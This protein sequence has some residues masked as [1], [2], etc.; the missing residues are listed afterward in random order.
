MNCFNRAYD[1]RRMVA[2]GMGVGVLWATPPVRAETVTGP[3][4]ALTD[5][6][7]A[8]STDPR[9]DHLTVDGTPVNVLVPP[10]Y[11]RG[12]R[13]YPVVYLFH[14][15]FSDEDSFSTQTDLLAYTAA[16]E[17]AQQALVVMPAGG[18]LPIGLDY[19]DG[20]QRQ[21]TFVFGTLIPFVDANYRTR[22]ERVHRAIAG[23]SAGG[24]N[25]MLYAARH[26]DMFVA[27]GS[28]SGF[29]DPFTSV[30]M[31][32]AQLFAA[33]DVQLCG[34]SVDWTSFWGDP[35][36][37]PFGWE[38]GDPTYFAGNLRG[39]A[40]YVG[41]DNGVPCPENPN[42]DPF[43]VF[44][45]QTVY[46]M[47]QALDQALTAAGIAHVTDFRACGVHE[48]SNSNH[49]LR[50]FWPMMISAFGRPGQ[51]QF[52][53]RAGD[54]VQSA[55]GWTFTA[56]PARAPEFLDVEDASRAGVKL[57]GSG[58]ERVL[59]APLFLPQR[60]VAV[61]GAQSVPQLVRANAAGAISFA[62]DL[63]P[64]HSLEEGTSAE[65]AAAS[66]ASPYF[67][68]REVRFVSLASSEG[69]ANICE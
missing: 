55:W 44:A 23:F 20:T 37:H 56:D 2:V 50:R 3:C 27:A 14:G 26:P 63:G 24:L 7:N 13:R 52:S 47:S 60:L 19:A 45:E 46:G 68:T 18:Y 36:V 61:V 25:A 31:Q 16:L 32:V 12:S 65:V 58:T 33:D 21:E 28:F 64:A 10:N 22:P 38:R 40:V 6:N 35:A 30:G 41:S 17:E 15:A 5:P 29:V 49:D 39:L 4:S 57:T 51:S 9:I 53:Y 54:A 69:S 8:P 1:V 43:L 62:A 59:T 66:G 67:V 11:R 34:G 42:P 48:F